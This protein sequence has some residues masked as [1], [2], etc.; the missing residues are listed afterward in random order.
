[1][2]G[3]HPASRALRLATE[4]FNAGDYFACHETLEPLWRRARGPRRELYQG[5]IQFAVALHHRGRGNRAGAATL[6]AKALGHLERAQG[7]NSPLHVPGLALQ[8]RRVQGRLRTQ[9][10]AG[11]APRIRLR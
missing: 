4:Q 1:V 2:T 11:P 5:L 8:V 9:G 10:A 6:L 3:S 7:I